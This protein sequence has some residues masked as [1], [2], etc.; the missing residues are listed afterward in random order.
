MS[1]MIHAR[2]YR[3]YTI[4]LIIATVI[5]LADIG[6]RD[7]ILRPAPLVK[8]Q[9]TREPCHK[10]RLSSLLLCV[11]GALHDDLLR[12]VLL[13]RP[14]APRRHVGELRGPISLRGRILPNSVTDS[15]YVA[16]TTE[17]V[18]EPLLCTPLQHKVCIG[19]T[20]RRLLGG[21]RYSHRCHH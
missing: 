15:T 18:N 11:L 6:G 9:K 8:P 16:I 10:A 13:G 19:R 2:P 14:A 12:W 1:L 20:T 7:V 5:M 21:D 3:A 4:P 17:L